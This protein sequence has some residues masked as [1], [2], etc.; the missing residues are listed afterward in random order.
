MCVDVCGCKEKGV[1]K[2]TWSVCVCVCMCVCS[3]VRKEKDISCVR[4]SGK[5]ANP[6]N[7]DVSG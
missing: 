5:D 2:R 3:C 4:V 6:N 7:P 1:R